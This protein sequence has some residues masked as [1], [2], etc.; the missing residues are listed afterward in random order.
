M[1]KSCFIIIL[2]SFAGMLSCSSED[3][4]TSVA[5]DI[6]SLEK[7][8]FQVFNMVDD[9]SFELSG[10]L[11]SFE[12]DIKKETILDLNYG[13]NHSY[14]HVKPGDKLRIDTISSDP[15]VFG[16]IGDVS[17]ENKYLESFTKTMQEASEEYMVSEVTKLPVDSFLMAVDKKNAPLSDLIAEINNDPD[18]SPEFKKAMAARF[19]GVT[20]NDLSY[21]K[22]F[23]K[24]HYEKYPEL[25]EDYYAS[26]TSSD[27]NDD[28]Y[29]LF[30]E[31]R[32]AVGS[33]HSRD[34]DYKEYD[35]LTDFYRAAIKSAR[36]LYGDSKAARYC[37]FDLLS[38]MINFGGGLDGATELISD[39][40]SFAPEQYFNNK[41]DK[42]IEPW[43]DLVAG[44]VAP[45][46]NAYNRSGE[47]V[48]LSELKGKKVYVDVWA[49]WCGPCIAEIPSLK[50]LEADLHEENIE[51]VSVSIDEEKDKEKWKEFIEERELTGLQLMAEGA[52]K[53]DVAVDYNIKGIPR[54]MLIDQ[55]GMIISAN[56]PRPSDPKINETLIN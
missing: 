18:I 17:Q 48:R 23:Y 6:S 35:G 7:S 54:F 36:D 34:V 29:L 1:S 49:T 13:W 14:V 47:P 2:F 26:F 28:S 42:V 25:P 31:G 11:D 8:E 30:E 53:S 52:W 9:I 55:E 44:K 3:P 50:K 12:M 46:F 40:R 43:K 39:F 27:I 15:I 4:K 33:Y 16:V 38:S 24:R 5:V 41:L 37:N 10:A 32:Q 51:F 19:V 56:A 20:T 45:D 22:G 21:Y